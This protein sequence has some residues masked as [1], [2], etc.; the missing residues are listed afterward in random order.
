MS[1]ISPELV[2]QAVAILGTDGITEAEIESNVLALA[3][4]PMLARR[5]ID[6]P[7]EA[8]GLVLAPHIA[9]VNLPTTFRARSKSGSWVELSFQLEPI[10]QAAVHLGMDMYHSEQRRTFGNVALRSSILDAVNN[11]LNEGES[12]EGATLAGPAL[13]GI[14]AEV[15]TPTAK[16]LWRRLFQ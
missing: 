13:I 6:W 11:A 3:K 8:F 16:S 7:P 15:Y 10:F 4:D 12:I 1:T 14:P 5:L 9:K 2:A